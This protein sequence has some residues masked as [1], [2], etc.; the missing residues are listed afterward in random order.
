MYVWRAG[1][2]SGD[3]YPHPLLCSTHGPI[4]VLP[5]H[6]HEGEV[7]EPWDL[8]A[9]LA[10]GA[11]SFVEYPTDVHGY[12]EKPQIVAWGKVIELRPTR[13]RRVPYTG[14][15]DYPAN[16]RPFGVVGAYDGH[17]VGVGRVA[18]DSTWHHFFDI[19][20]I[21]DPVAAFPKTQGFRASPEGLAVPC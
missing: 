14:E 11:K 9:S 19:N 5:D 10:F 2:L 15:P 21:G 17:R 20:L 3:F 8:S 13:A 18:V 7:I 1:F 4:D 16:A 6:M 12:Q